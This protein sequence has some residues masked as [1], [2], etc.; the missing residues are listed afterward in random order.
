MPLNN[1]NTGLITSGSY[2]GDSSANRAIA[3]GLRAV[4][5]M[6]FILRASGYGWYRIHGY[7]ARIHYGDESLF[8]GH[9]VTQPDGTSF[10]V[11]NATSYPQ[12]ANNTGVTYYWV[13]VT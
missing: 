9:S 5:K 2:T 12:S 13:A 11:G 4:P 1:P 3:H 7:E 10:Y 6:V 8:T